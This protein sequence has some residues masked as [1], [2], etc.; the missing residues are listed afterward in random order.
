[1][2]VID[3]SA[4]DR[5]LE[6]I[7]RRG[8]ALVGPRRQDDAIVYDA[9][10][11]AADLPAGWTD[12]QDKGSCRLKETGSGALFGYTT[13]AQSWKRFLYPPTALLWRAR[14]NSHK[15]DIVD[16]ESRMD[17]PKLAF[18]GVRPCELKAI[19]IQDNVFVEGLY[20]DRCYKARRDNALIV[21]VNCGRAGG[22]CFC[23]SM[24]AGPRA[25]GGFDLA[26]TEILED[27]RHYF[28]VESAS[29]MGTDI[30]A[31]LQLPE[32][33]AAERAAAD[34]VT[35]A[36]EAG[37]GR[38]VD[39]NGLAEA[40]VR[41]REDGHWD[42]VAKR[43]LTCA[44]CTLVCPTCF[45]HKVEDVTDLS[46]STAERW[47]KWDSCFTIDFSYIHGGSV[48]KTASSRYRQW[49]MHKFSS[50]HEQ[51]GTSGC[52]GCGRCITWCPAG[53]DVTEEIRALRER[54]GTAPAEKQPKKE[55]SHA[56]T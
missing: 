10:G 25:A 28:T 19:A 30:L 38:S 51:F 7:R 22:T 8:Y 56:G 43:C 4:F 49:L 12:E 9:I 3:R 1:M 2:H 23:A 55:T 37:I 48:R 33:G 52:V 14:R 36:A 47:R 21:A 15:Y 27:G 11:S 40:L 13:A 53:I 45:C 24:G 20:I 41:H 6:A 5:L 46:G 42:D 39:T 26:L 31:E 50:W 34:R 35:A 44:N 54:D 32:A 16:T 29:L 17:V 18:V